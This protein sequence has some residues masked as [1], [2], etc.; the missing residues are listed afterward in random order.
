MSR[1]HDLT[2]ALLHDMS[3]EGSDDENEDDGGNHATLTG[4]QRDEEQVQ[5][6]FTT[7]LPDEYRVPES[8]V[9]VP[10]HLSRYG[11]SEVINFLLELSTY[12]KHTRSLSLSL[13]N[14]TY[15]QH[16]PSRSTSSSATSSCAPR[17]DST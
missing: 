11:L 13:S 17:F 12:H 8:S 10:A 2:D 7:T 3:P 6:S 15:V 4:E 5:V 1:N 9:L 14:A 16:R